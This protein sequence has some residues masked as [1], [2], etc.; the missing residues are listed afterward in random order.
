MGK[1]DALYTVKQYTDMMKISSKKK[2]VV[3]HLETDSFKDFTKG[4]NF[5]NLSK[6]VDTD[7]NKFNWMNIH[8]FKY[9][10]GLFGFK[11]RYTLDEEYR[12]CL[13]GPRRTPQQPK[14]APKFTE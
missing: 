7:G 9:E 11:F 14:P 10:V 2:P 8:E 12:T 6:P 5:K 4:S 3:Y 13:L 1:K